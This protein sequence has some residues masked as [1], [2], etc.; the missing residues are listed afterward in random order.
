M[1]PSKSVKRRGRWTELALSETHPLI[2]VEVHNVHGASIIYQ[3]YVYISIGHSW[4]YDQC[5]AMRM[6]HPYGVCFCKDNVFKLLWALFIRLS[7][8]LSTCVRGAIRTSLAYL[9][10]AFW[11]S[12]ATM[13]LQR[14]SALLLFFLGF[15]VVVVH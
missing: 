15:A 1:I 5:V 12:P 4:S 6:V 8:V 3:H 7:S 9:S 13:V 11:L 10:L 14:W 2:Y